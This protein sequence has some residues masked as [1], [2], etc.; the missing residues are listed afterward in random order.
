MLVY[1]QN[2][3]TV[4][5]SS[6]FYRVNYDTDNWQQLIRQL[7]DKPTDIHVLNRAQLIDDSFAL[8]R[9]GQ[10]NYSVPLSLSNYL[11]NETDIVPWYTA[12]NSLSYLLERMPR[13]E[14]GYKN[15][16]VNHISAGPFSNM[17]VKFLLFSVC[18]IISVRWLGSFITDSIGSCHKTISI[19]TP[20]ASG[21][22]SR[23]GRAVWI[24][25][26]VM[27]RCWNTSKNGNREKSQ[28]II[29]YRVV[30]LTVF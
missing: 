13:N 5:F 27:P 11:K 2:Y 23:R 10:L 1:K 21:T 22:R 19:S 25:P 24:T 29:V 17:G 15:F 16:K 6:G 28:L 20:W 14:D 18:R 9:A 3:D 26:I 7:N 4:D 12:M 8:A 30:Y